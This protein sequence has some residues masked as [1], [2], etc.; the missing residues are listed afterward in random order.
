[1]KLPE[2]QYFGP[3]SLDEACSLLARYGEDASALAG[4][5]DLLGCLRDNVLEADKVVGISQLADLRGIK[6]GTGGLEKYGDEVPRRGPDHQSFRDSKI[7]NSFRLINLFFDD[8]FLVSIRIPHSALRIQ[9]GGSFNGR[10]PDSD[11]ANRGSTPRPPA[12][13]PLSSR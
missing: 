12:N 10:T 2:F 9:N 6:E 4:G 13:F 7:K 5:T 8:I 1:M 11:S 3:K